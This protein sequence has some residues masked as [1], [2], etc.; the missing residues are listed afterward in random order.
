MFYCFSNFNGFVFY[1]QHKQ[2]CFMMHPMHLLCCVEKPALLNQAGLLYRMK[3][4][5]LT[6]KAYVLTYMLNQTC[7]LYV[8]PMLHFF[9]H[10]GR[11]NICMSDILSSV[12]QWHQDPSSAIW[13]NSVLHCYQDVARLPKLSVST[14]AV[15][16]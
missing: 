6:C 12:M 5:A 10:N 3:P 16:I 13:E 14:S 4:W 15:N 7:L 11:A 8:P 9:T 2:F 1:F